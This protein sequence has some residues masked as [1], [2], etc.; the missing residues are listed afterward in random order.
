M[1][2]RKTTTA[3]RKSRPSTIDVRRTANV[4]H[5]SALKAKAMTG[6]ACGAIAAGRELVSAGWRFCAG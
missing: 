3:N 2:P 1:A 4:D 6:G 5:F